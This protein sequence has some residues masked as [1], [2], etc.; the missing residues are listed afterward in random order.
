VINYLHSL[1]LIIKGPS[2]IYAQNLV[3][4][5]N[6]SVISKG[7]S[8]SCEHLISP[9]VVITHVFGKHFENPDNSSQFIFGINGKYLRDIGK[10]YSAKISMKLF[11]PITE[12]KAPAFFRGRVVLNSSPDLQ[13]IFSIDPEQVNEIIN[14]YLEY[15]R[16]RIKI[17]NIA[18]KKL[19][20]CEIF[21]FIPLLESFPVPQPQPQPDNSNTY[22]ELL[23]VIDSNGFMTRV[24]ADRVVTSSDGQRLYFISYGNPYISRS[25]DRGATRMSFFA[26]VESYGRDIACSSDGRIVVAIL[27]NELSQSSVYISNSYGVDFHKVV[28][29]SGIQLKSIAMSSTGDKIYITGVNEGRP[30]VFQSFNYSESFELS[31]SFNLGSSLYFS[32][33]DHNIS[34]SENCGVIITADPGVIQFTTTTTNF[35]NNTT[36]T[37]SNTRIYTL[38]Y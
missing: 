14:T 18:L 23:P 3:Q 11:N 7:E 8:E 6:F 24:C 12:I 1:L 20:G 28:F 31:S 36:T 21:E 4:N 34:C 10:N 5:K 22:S 13:I 19:V 33:S 38:V 16:I 2:E 27:I 25:D 17:K 9:Q 35:I 37:H 32:S 30:V 15:S 29:S 26:S